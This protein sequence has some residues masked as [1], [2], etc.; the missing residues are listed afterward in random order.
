MSFPFDLK[1][2]PSYVSL[3]TG[4]TL[5]F[6]DQNLSQ[7]QFEALPLVGLNGGIFFTPTWGG[8][9]E[10]RYQE[11]GVYGGMNLSFSF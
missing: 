4:S 1:E 3:I 9:V 2:M 5:Y 11:N 6:V 8:M 10:V 7:S